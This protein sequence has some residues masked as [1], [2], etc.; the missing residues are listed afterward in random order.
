[1]CVVV[2]VATVLALAAVDRGGCNNQCV[3]Q[4]TALVSDRIIERLARTDGNP[5]D[6]ILA[7]LCVCMCAC[8]RRQV[9]DL[10]SRMGPD[11]KP[12]GFLF[13]DWFCFVESGW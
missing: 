1:M 3:Q 10:A 9:H 12:S 8:V 13:F 5:L 6:L 4:T 7:L 2:V 11:A